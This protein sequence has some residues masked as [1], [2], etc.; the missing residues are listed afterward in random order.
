[1]DKWAK[2]FADLKDKAADLRNKTVQNL[3][4]I[5]ERQAAAAEASVGPAESPSK[6]PV[7][8]IPLSEQTRDQLL[9]TANRWVPRGPRLPSACTTTTTTTRNYDHRH[10]RVVLPQ[11]WPDLQAATSQAQ[12][13]SDPAPFPPSLPGLSSSFVSTLVRTSLP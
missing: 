5:A 13:C 3:K 10:H 4:E 2:G 11:V 6:A 9:E 12:R 1:M 7:L 8:R